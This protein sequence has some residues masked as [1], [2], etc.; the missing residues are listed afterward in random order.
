MIHVTVCEIISWTPA[1]ASCVERLGCFGSLVS[2][3][4]VLFFFSSI[5]RA[6]VSV[7]ELVQY[8]IM[9]PIL[10]CSRVDILGSNPGRLD[11]SFYI[12]SYLRR[13][14]RE[15]VSEKIPR[16][17][18]SKP[19]VSTGVRG[20]GGERMERDDTVHNRKGCS[21]KTISVAFV[22]PYTRHDIIH[23]YYGTFVFDELLLLPSLTKTQIYT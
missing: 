17:P 18:R 16:S 13:G 5:Y 6:P 20:G 4:L 1:P 3:F 10:V 14:K 15:G 12:L 23:I 22:Q 2:S 7:V 9:L 8:T 11:T 19:K 21:E